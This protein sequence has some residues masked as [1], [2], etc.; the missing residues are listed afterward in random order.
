MKRI[1]RYGLAAAIMATSTMAGAQ[2]RYLDEVFTDAEISVQQDVT[3]GLNVDFMKN[4]QLLDPSYLQANITQIMSEVTNLKTL[5]QTGQSAN[6]PTSH[7]F[8]Y[9]M[10]TN[11]IVKISEIKM[12]LYYPDMAA[13]TMTD[14]PV[15]VYIHSGNFLPPVINGSYG[16]S[17]S[18][19]AAV[20]LCMQW[21]KRG[22]VAAAPNYRHGW[23][24][25]ATGPTG[26]FVR[27]AT[28]LNAVYRSIHDVKESIRMIRAMSATLNTSTTDVGIYG[29]GSG[30]YVALAY[31]TLDQW[32]EVMLPKFTNP[33]TGG[34][35]IDT[36]VVGNF[37]GYDGLLNLYYDQGLSSDI[38][39]SVNAGGALAD[40]SWIDG[41]EAP[42][43][44]LHAPRDP[45]APYD[46]GT[47]I[48]PTTGDPVVDVNGPNTFMPLFNSLG[49]N[50]AF[51]SLPDNDDYTIAAR[52]TYGMDV[53]QMPIINTSSTVTIANAEG[54]YPFIMG[55]NEGSPWDWWDLDDLTNYVAA[56]NQLT[57]GNYD[58]NT[59]HQNGLAT[60]PDMSETK[61]LTYID[62][63]QGYIHPR[64]MRSMQIGNWEALGT[65][66]IVSVNKQFAIY[67][68]PANN[69]FTVQG[70]KTIDRVEIIDLTGRVVLSRE[71][72]AMNITFVVEDLPTGVY[73]VQ[74]SQEG[75]S[76]TERL[77]IE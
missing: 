22:Y 15:L 16:G 75:D 49:V 1:L 33:L 59:I 34:S 77:V 11:T 63:I 38:E 70:E 25:V 40:I 30:G 27:T 64:I 31:N 51:A 62:T 68:N 46:T 24:P 53:D 4:L 67:P 18:D 71:V 26:Q 73:L 43:I 60:N 58:A 13:D 57:G 17:N 65:E 29:Q 36:T 54:L 61:A 35:V 28:L 6:I 7:F 8:P 76:Y 44:T 42:Q 14:R 47:V 74:V 41:N 52:A 32:E 56:I 10:D 19:S 66:E 48:V 9:S 23:N 39:V 45:F 5:I 55:P 69:Q 72:G 20:E 21:A 2:E 12:D 37:E 50:D 3:Y